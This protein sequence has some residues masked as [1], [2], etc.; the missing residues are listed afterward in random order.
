MQVTKLIKHRRLL[1]DVASYWRVFSGID[2]AQ[3]YKIERVGAG[4]ESLRAAKEL[5]AAVY[6][7]RSFVHP[8][9]VVDG[10][11]CETSDP[12][13]NHSEYFVV[14][15]HHQ[16]V[17]LAR[18]INF[19]GEGRHQESFP[20]LEKAEL[21]DS[22]QHKI[23]KYHPTEIV[24]ISALAKASGESSV[25][26]L[27]L[28]RAL[29]NHSLKHGHQ[30]WLMACDPRLYSRLELLFGDALERI[31][32]P[33][34]YVGAPALPVMISVN[35]AKEY[36]DQVLTSKKYSRYSIQY[37]AVKFISRKNKDD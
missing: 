11:I 1:K 17:A 27:I 5:H 2:A 15:K 18:Q 28:Y 10:I 23:L 13:Q 4:D 30:L 29:W 34:E 31:G 8:T 9:D 6:L 22:A 14:K 32:E 3:Q 37:Q 35:K 19:R 12:H 33:A 20:V 24:E 25:V 16:V 26:P 7:T 21:D 36:I